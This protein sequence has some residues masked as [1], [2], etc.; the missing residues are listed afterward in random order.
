MQDL[1]KQSVRGGVTF[2]LA[3]GEQPSAAAA[4]VPVLIIGATAGWTPA[5]R[6]RPQ[7]RSEESFRQFFSFFSFCFFACLKPFIYLFLSI[8]LSTLPCHQALV[9]NW[10]PHSPTSLPG[11]PE[12]RFIAKRPM[13]S[14][15]PRFFV[16]ICPILFSRLHPSREDCWIFS[17]PLPT[18]LFSRRAV[19]RDAGR[20]A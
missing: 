13:G 16:Q 14:E 5:G 2:H 17:Q 7:L 19:F 3:D 11:S 9:S 10:F 1:T 18:I 12:P 15:I 4:T 6:L 8:F 20:P